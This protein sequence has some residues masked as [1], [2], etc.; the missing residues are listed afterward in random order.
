MDAR[1][2]QIAGTSGRPKLVD[3]AGEATQRSSQVSLT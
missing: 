2:P 1:R 3:R